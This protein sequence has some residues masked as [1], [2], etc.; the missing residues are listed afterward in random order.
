MSEVAK[1]TFLVTGGA[2]G[3]GLLISEELRNRDHSVIVWDRAAPDEGA[4]GLVSVDVRDPDQ[5]SAAAESLP[6]LLNGVV[7]CAGIASRESI[8]DLTPNEWSRVIDVNL[9]GTFHVAQSCFSRL[10]EAQGTF[11][12]LGSV[13]GSLAIGNRSAYCVSKA[14]VAMLTRCLALEWG[15]QGVRAVSLAPGFT[16]SG[17]S[18]QGIEQ[19][20]TNA[21]AVRQRTPLRELVPAT[22][23]ATLAADILEQRWSAIT[24]TEIVIDGGL[25]TGW[26]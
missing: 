26:S 5:V 22:Q 3:L 10:A 14:A 4:P 17:M 2:S 21:D 6:A 25:S 8:V 13:A 7:T 23:I 15:P 20:R 9:N 19:G 18:A 12:T 1:Q 16:D 11:I 24:G